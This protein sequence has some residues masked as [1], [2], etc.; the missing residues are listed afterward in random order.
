MAMRSWCRDLVK[1]LI[2]KK[3]SRRDAIGRGVFDGDQRLCSLLH[4]SGPGLA[5]APHATPVSKNLRPVLTELV[6]PNTVACIE[7]GGSE[8]VSRTP[9]FV[10][11]FASMA[12][13]PV[14]FG[15][16]FLQS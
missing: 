14:H 12:R 4:G 9:F 6:Q 15:F 1:K 16:D 5:V 8:I 10:R 11:R 7:C 13:V 3:A 2:E